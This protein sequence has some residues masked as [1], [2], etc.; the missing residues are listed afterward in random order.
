VSDKHILEEIGRLRD[1]GELLGPLVDRFGADLVVEAL[2]VHHIS[3]SLGVR[4]ETMYEA[5]STWHCSNCGDQLHGKDAE[6]STCWYRLYIKELKDTLAAAIPLLPTTF[7][8][9]ADAVAIH[10]TRLL[11]HGI[12]IQWNEAKTEWE[13][14]RE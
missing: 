6:C 8:N 13:V 9:L 3:A 14:V 11:E 12:K 2:G 4:G 10:A 5:T 1:R 7:D